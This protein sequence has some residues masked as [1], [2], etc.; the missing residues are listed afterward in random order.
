[1]YLLYKLPLLLPT[2]L[3]STAFLTNLQ[4]LNL[5]TNVLIILQS[6]EKNMTLPNFSLLNS[7][8]KKL[9]SKNILLSFEINPAIRRLI[10]K[11]PKILKLLFK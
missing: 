6:Y 9:F 8:K 10:L 1:M 2:L 7:Q 11:N 4:S 3:I 5:P